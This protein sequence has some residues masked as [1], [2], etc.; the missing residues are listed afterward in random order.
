[1]WGGSPDPCITTLVA[2][3]SVSKIRSAGLV[4]DLRLFEA[5][6]HPVRPD[7][8]RRSLTS[9]A[10]RSLPQIVKAFGFGFPAGELVFG[11]WFDADSDSD[12]VRDLAFD[13]VSR[14]AASL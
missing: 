14:C 3:E 9:P 4:R 7:E 10:L 5:F 1:M 11:Y 8:G 12:L 2:C 13:L 6:T